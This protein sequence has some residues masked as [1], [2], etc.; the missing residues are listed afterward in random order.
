MN[1]RIQIG[2]IPPGTIIGG[3][4]PPRFDKINYGTVPPENKTGGL[5]AY[6]P[7][8]S[9][10]GNMDPRQQELNKACHDKAVSRWADHLAKEAQRESYFAKFMEPDGLIVVK[11]DDYGR[12]MDQVQLAEQ[13]QVMEMA[14]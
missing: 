10:V 5:E 14:A 13:Y 8:Q 12:V 6:W 1:D 4:A 9:V 2:T 7:K 3:N 11:D